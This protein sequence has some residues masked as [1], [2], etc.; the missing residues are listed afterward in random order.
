MLPSL[1]RLA[2]KINRLILIL[3]LIGLVCPINTVSAQ[4]FIIDP[5]HSNVQI[6]VERFGVVDVIG[7]FKAVSGTITFDATDTSK[8]KANATIK[9]G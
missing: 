2:M 7:R 4:N 1:K 6:K 5:G 8:T 3:G 9:S